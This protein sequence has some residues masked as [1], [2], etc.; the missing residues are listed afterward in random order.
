MLNAVIRL[1]L[2]HRLL[3]LALAMLI[4]GYGGWQAVNLPIDVFPD[5]NRP[6]VTVITEAHGLAP[7]EIESRITLPLESAL[8]GAAGVLTVR[9]SSGLGMSI[10][11]VEFDWG[12]DVYDD[13]QI[14]NEK[15]S[16]VSEQLPEGAETTLSPMSSIMGQIMIVGIYSEQNDKTRLFTIPLALRDDLSLDRPSERLRS[17]L[18]EHDVSG[19]SPSERLLSALAEYDD[20]PLEN[21]ELRDDRSTE[22]WFVIDHTNDRW[23]AIVPEGQSLAVHKMTS[24][25]AARTLAD[26]KVR[27]RLMVPGVA[28]VFVMGG[29]RKQF[30]VLVQPDRLLAFGVTIEQVKEAVEKSNANVTGGYLDD[31]G[32]HELL[33]RTI[34]RVTTARDL[35]ALVVELRDDRPVLLRQVAQVVEAPQVKRGDSAAW[36]RNGE[37][38]SGG[39]AIVLTISKQPSADTSRVSEAILKKLNTMKLPD[40]LKVAPQLYQQKQFIDLAVHNVREALLHGGILVVVILFIFLLNFRTTLI[41]LTAIPLSIVVTALVF[42]WFGL[43][44]NTMTLGGL[45]VAIGELVD[46]AIVDVE[47]IYRRL[48]ENSKRDKPLPSLLVVYRAST[49]IRN[50]IVFGTAIVVVVFIPLFALEGMEGRLFAPLGVAYIVSILSSLVVSLTVT[51]VLCSWLLP[52]AKFMHRERESLLVR[53]CQAVAGRLIGFAVKNPAAVLLSAAAAAALS[54]MVLL[55]LE[56]DFLPPFNEGSFQVNVILPPGTSLRKSRETVDVVE[57]RLREIDDVTAIVSKTGRAELDE[58][59]AGVNRTEM[60][61]SIN[62]DSTRPREETLEEIRNTLGEVPGIVSSTE[63][64][65]SHLISHMLS[66]VKAQIGIKLYGDNL[67]VLRSRGAEILA[68]ISSV[69]GVK[70]ANIEQQ[71]IIPQLRI[72]H[73]RDALARNGLTPDDVNHLIE[74]AM[75]GEVVSSVLDGRKSFDLVVRMDERS[76]ED[77]NNLERLAIPLP[78]GGTIPLGQVARITRNGGPNTINREKVERR[79]IISCNTAGRGLVDV[80]EDI[81]AKIEPIK[82]ALP[83]GYHVEF[84]GQFESQQSASRMLTILSCVSLAGMFLL[85]YTMFRSGGFAL[86]VMAALPMA[87]IGSVVALVVTNQ[88]LTI[89]AMVGFISLCGIA[90]RNGILLLNHYL[91]LVR[92]EGESWSASMIIRAGRER[93]SPVLMTA[94]TSGIGL[95]PLALAAGE[96][97]KE[98]LYPVATVIIG[99]LISSTALEFLVR[100]ALFWTFGRREGERLIAES[101]SEVSLSDETVTDDPDAATAVSI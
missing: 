59:A 65:L 45:A 52:K 97:G 31:Q 7:E 55:G 40:D 46:D 74:T 49:E 25:M 1:A 23:L 5:L 41:T 3:V 44:I 85:L 78:G 37:S 12:T 96:P 86:Q 77:I 33:V 98:I 81:K 82:T 63:Q 30:Q 93:L 84:S 95:V 100:P 21:F 24:P 91:H 83:T 47:N 54:V 68:A 15:I 92:Y 99:G 71:V 4:L 76:R 89:A 75:N 13:R 43:S 26:W 51:P 94:L 19:D 16:Q 56:R 10:V 53:A 88:T 11:N 70:D 66:G 72:E 17:A 69:D 28:Q 32:P 73:R 87:L 62:P 39:S 57:A 79:I 2:R 60:I 64:P 20:R 101:R 36:E 67:D 27:Q 29:G 9:S 6:R 18:A 80:V 61:L 42:R 50:S 22:R 38:F 48:R 34:G 35:E 90:S 14:V 8:N 58:H